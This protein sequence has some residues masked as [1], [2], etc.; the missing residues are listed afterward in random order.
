MA[1]LGDNKDRRERRI[2]ERRAKLQ[3]QASA[4]TSASPAPS[5]KKL[6][7]KVKIKVI[8]GAI[9][10]LLALFGILRLVDYLSS[11]TEVFLTDEGFTH[12]DRFSDCVVLNGID[13]STHQGEDINWKKV[14]TGGAEFVFIR[15]G[16]RSADDGSLHED[17]NFA[18][19]LKNANKAGLMT[20]VYF[21]SQALTPAEAEEEADY[22]M[23][24]IKGKDIDLPVVIDFEIYPDGRLNQ[25]IDAG[26][27]Y[28]ASLYH[29]IV[30]AFCRKVEAAGY[31]SAVYANLDMLT[32]YMD[33]SLLD[34]S[35]TIWLAQYSES[36]SLE[37]DYWFWQATDS[38]QVGGIEGNVDH[39]FWYLEPGKVYET[40]S[41]GSPGPRI[42]IGDCKIKFNK[43]SYKI[44][45]RRAVPKLSLRCGGK[46]MREGSDYTLS[47]VNNTKSG[48]GYVIIRGKGLYK[49]WIM[50]PFTI[51]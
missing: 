28:A 9:V 16:Y 13:V 31:E 15:A 40:R 48:T 22:C 43:D 44:K 10:L 24:L 46:N 45:N 2:E 27:L 5:K 36:P 8:A 14:K 30:L 18:Q 38:G 41:A 42:S 35:G 49:D 11:G 20:G 37:A 34:D 3:E 47:V 7:L 17:E 50:L 1:I 25:K 26:E 33:A 12:A 32:H 51:E 19:N 39:D 29:D 23:N 4:R 21:Y 6:P